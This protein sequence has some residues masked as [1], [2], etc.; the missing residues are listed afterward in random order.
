MIATN[1]VVYIY[2]LINP[3]NNHVF[4]IG[5]SA[6]VQKRLI[7]HIAERRQSDSFKNKK[8]IEILSVGLKPELLVIDE[9]NPDDATFWENFYMDLYSSYGFELRQSRYSVYTNGADRSYL[10]RFKSYV[11][12]GNVYC[13]LTVDRKG[14]CR[15]FHAV[16]S[17][18]I[19]IKNDVI[20][21]LRK[22]YK[23]KC[24]SDNILTY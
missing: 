14:L 9:C 23:I 19:Y 1:D 10:E 11:H 12:N 15:D 18:D 8:I 13:K 5:A 22:A 20:E 2:A 16:V 21:F 3:I 4:Y 24:L 6:D 7:C 17:I